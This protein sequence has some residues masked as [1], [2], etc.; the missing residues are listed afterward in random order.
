MGGDGT[1]PR[2]N[3]SPIKWLVPKNKKRKRKE[4]PQVERQSIEYKKQELSTWSGVKIT[5]SMSCVILGKLRHYRLDTRDLT[6]VHIIQRCI[7][8]HGYQLIVVIAD[9]HTHTPQLA[10]PSPYTHT[11]KSKL[12]CVKQVQLANNRANPHTIL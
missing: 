7:A 1:K 5:L 4:V 6:S 11:E 2:E 9:T 3:I 12:M 10:P 8:P